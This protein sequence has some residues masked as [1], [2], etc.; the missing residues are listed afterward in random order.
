M[1][2][3]IFFFERIEI[4]GKPIIYGRPDLILNPC[5][6]LE[7]GTKV[8]Q[9]GMPA[10]SGKIT[11]SAHVD[12][13]TPW[14]EYAGL[15]DMDGDLFAAFR[16]PPGGVAPKRKAKKHLTEVDGIKL[17]GE[18]YMVYAMFG[19]GDLLEVSRTRNNTYLYRGQFILY[20][21]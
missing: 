8:T 10:K 1:Q 17:D 12:E 20:N 4:H 2:K 9:I 15:V 7:P 16:L 11:S 21:E 14:V 5:Y 3:S 18:F 13:W 19:D 6:G